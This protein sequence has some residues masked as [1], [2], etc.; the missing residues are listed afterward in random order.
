MAGGWQAT[1]K[2][3]KH[4][5]KDEVSLVIMATNPLPCHYEW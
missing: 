1:S 2:L 4:Y 5:G 3:S